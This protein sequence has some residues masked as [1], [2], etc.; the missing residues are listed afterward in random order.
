MGQMLSLNANHTTEGGAIDDTRTLHVGCHLAC[1]QARCELA[2]LCIIAMVEGLNLHPMICPTVYPLLPTICKRLWQVSNVSV[3]HK[4]LDLLFT[5]AGSTLQGELTI[6]AHRVVTSGGSSN[7]LRQNFQKTFVGLHLKSLTLGFPFLILNF[8]HLRR[9]LL[10]HRLCILLLL[11]APRSLDHL[12]ERMT[13]AH[14][15]VF[16]G[17]HSLIPGATKIT[18]S[19]KVPESAEFFLFLFVCASDLHSA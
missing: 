3:G 15:P 13:H 16:Q 11:C 17:G 19:K 12:T 8:A 10:H 4:T 5:D 2:S 9:G 14:S 6:Y 1:F 18:Y 7:E